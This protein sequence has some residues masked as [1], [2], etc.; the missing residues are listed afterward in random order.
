MRFPFRGVREAVCQEVPM[1]PGFS[2]HPVAESAVGGSST[3]S[4]SSRRDATHCPA[5]ENGISWRLRLAPPGFGK[6]TVERGRRRSGD[7]GP[8]RDPLGR[9]IKQR[10]DIETGHE[11]AVERAHRG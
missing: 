9:K 7:R 3:K 6:I 4:L 2:A 5:T 11:H 10:D 1:L 8:T